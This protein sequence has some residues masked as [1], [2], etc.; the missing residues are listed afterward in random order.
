VS[1]LHRIDDWFVGRVS[2]PLTNYLFNRR[3]VLA[4]CRQLL[5]SEYYPE[6]QLQEMQLRKFRAVLRHAGQFCPYYTSKFRQ[7]GVTPEDIKSLEDVRR[8]PPLSRQ[9]VAE[10]CREMIDARYRHSLPQAQ[11]LSR[12]PGQPVLL[13]RFRSGTLVRNS[14]SGSTGAPLVF[15]DDGSISAASW[16]F[17]LRLRHWYGIEA[18]AREARMMRMLADY[19]PNDRKLWARKRLW[20]QLVLPGHGLTDKEYAF[21]VQKLREFKPRVLWG[22]TPALTGLAEYI[23]RSGDD[24]SSFRPELTIAWAAPLYQHEEKLLKDVFHCA[25]SS[26]YS[27]REVGHIGAWCPSHTLHVNQEQMLVE[28]NASPEHGRLGEIIVTPLTLSPMPFI[29][30]RLGDLGQVARS[31]CA[32]GRTLQTIKELLGRTAEIFVTKDGRAITPGFWCR[33]FATGGQSDCVDR[34]QIVYR[35][36]DQISIRVVR[37]NGFSESIEEEMRRTLRKNFSPEI[38]FQFEY[39]PHIAPQA[40]GKYQIV[41]NEVGRQG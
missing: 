36:T 14:S 15:Y 31:Q 11:G 21:C 13:G 26:L 27:A 17:E 5:K 22:F 23:R 19:M 9:D 39:V 30:Y 28:S 20:H 10:H 38:R 6:E 32:C 3:G 41:V 12:A 37:R 35:Q 18:G 1:A 2:F 34:F 40:S 7:L 16:A 29:R 4:S 24:A 25:V 8:I 33:L